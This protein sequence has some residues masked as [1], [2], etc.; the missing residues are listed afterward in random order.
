[1]TV[2]LL[3]CGLSMMTG[4]LASAAEKNVALGSGGMNA[5][6]R[7][8]LT[9]GDSGVF[10][11]DLE[12]TLA[13]FF[14]VKDQIA[15]TVYSCDD[16]ELTVSDNGQYRANGSG[17]VYLTVQG[18]N[19]EGEWLFYITY[20]ITIRPD[21]SKAVL[22]KT[23]LQYYQY[24][25]TLGGVS[26]VV[27]IV[28]AIGLS[29]ASVNIDMTYV[30]TNTKMSVSCELSGSSLVISTYDTG[31]TTLRITIN[32]KTFQLKLRVTR[33]RLSGANSLYLIK[34]KTKNLKLKGITKK[35]T[36]KSSNTKVLTVNKNG[37]IKA[38]KEGNAVITAKIGSG[39]IGCVVSVVTKKR[40]QVINRAIQIG[41]T[42]TYSQAKRMQAKYYDC[43]SLVWKA[44]SK[45]KIY[46]GMKYYAPTAANNAKWC[47]AHKKI[48]KGNNAKNIQKMKF[49]PGALMFET[50]NAKNGR[51]KGIYHVEMFVG[52]TFEG[53]DSSGKVVVGTKW[54]N[55]PNNY[56]G[57]G[58][59]W[60]QP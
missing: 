56:Y 24:D 27:P 15:K 45:M 33:V 19:S 59:L 26:T 60:A 11:L 44:Y 12:D 57:A 34:G 51:Y 43:S 54:A 29:D 50:S 4:E 5:E 7:I 55:R 32:E 53:Y 22:Q 47:A 2:M 30:S 52:Y 8:P 3:F 31:S 46:F 38:K 35:A 18:Y 48:V 13:P 21:M 6:D 20:F 36:W 41:K 37:K 25:N 58:D 42:C 17:H 14:L 23:S 28:G 9:A 49:K 39:K 10:I 40:K 16:E 1:M